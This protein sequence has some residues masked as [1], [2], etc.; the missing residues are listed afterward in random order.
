M[1]KDLSHVRE[2]LFDTLDKLRSKE[3]DIETAKSIT[4]VSQ[5]LLNS[6]K[7]EMDFLKHTDQV[8]SKFFDAEEAA[9]TLEI[10]KEK[11]KQLVASKEPEPEPTEEIDKVL[12][13]I[14]EKK[15]KPYEFK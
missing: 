5:T 4:D 9:N 15:Q 8:R 13:E 1:S 10:A 7:L 14:E 12:K 6:A 3:I 11:H 2:A